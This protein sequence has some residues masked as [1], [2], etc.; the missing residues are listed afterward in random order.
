MSGGEEKKTLSNFRQSDKLQKVM[1]N[2]RLD[3]SPRKLMGHLL[4]RIQ[5]TKYRRMYE[6]SFPGT[7]RLSA[8]HHRQSRGKLLK[9]IQQSI[10]SP[11]AKSG[12]AQGCKTAE[13]TTCSTKQNICHHQKRAPKKCSGRATQRRRIRSSAV[14][15][16]K[17]FR[18]EPYSCR[19]L[20]YYSR[21]S[22]TV[23]IMVWCRKNILVLMYGR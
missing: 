21:Q 13:I 2:Q 20:G 9:I 22:P 5:I 19:F 14:P 23:N 10:E 12:K 8:P 3:I 16:W 1:K 17:R 11:N 18:T 7:N 4:N 6:S 15:S